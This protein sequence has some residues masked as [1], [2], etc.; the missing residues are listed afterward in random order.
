MNSHQTRKRSRQFIEE[1]TKLLPAEYNAE[2]TKVMLEQ[3][4]QID[5]MSGQLMKRDG[6]VLNSVGEV[7]IIDC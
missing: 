2:L 1:V 3:Q 4:R 5:V 7:T 6:Y